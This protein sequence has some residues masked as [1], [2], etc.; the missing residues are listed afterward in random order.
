MTIVSTSTCTMFQPTSDTTN[1]NKQLDTASRGTRIQRTFSKIASKPNKG[2][3][4]SDVSTTSSSKKLPGHSHGS[5]LP[6]TPTVCRDTPPLTCTAN[7]NR[8][9]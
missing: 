1:R 9:K 5:P 2:G 7:T 6:E 8:S 3:K 4:G